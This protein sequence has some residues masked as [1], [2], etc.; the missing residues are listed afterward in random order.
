V[1]RKESKKATTVRKKTAIYIFPLLSLLFVNVC[2]LSTNPSRELENYEHLTP[3]SSLLLEFEQKEYAVQDTYITHLDPA[4]NFGNESYLHVSNH[5]SGLSMIFLYFQITTKVYDKSVFLSLTSTAGFGNAVLSLYTV[6]EE[7]DEYNVTF[8]KCPPIGEYIQNCSQG[9]RLANSY[10]YT[11]SFDVTSAIQNQPSLN[12][13]IILENSTDHEIFFSREGS[14]GEYSPRLIWSPNEQGLLNIISPDPSISYGIE[15]P[16]RIEWEYLGPALGIVN[17]QF[18][19]LKSY[20]DGTNNKYVVVLES[21]ANISMNETTVLTRNGLLFDYYY[22]FNVFFIKF[23]SSSYPAM[24]ICSEPFLTHTQMCILPAW[25][26]FTSLLIFLIPLILFVISIII[27][28]RH[29]KKKQDIKMFSP[30]ENYA[31]NTELDGASQGISEKGNQK[32]QDLPGSTDAK[33][34]GSINESNGKLMVVPEDGVRN[35]Q[36][37]QDS[38]IVNLILTHGINKGFEIIRNVLDD[39]GDVDKS[40]L[41]SETLRRMNNILQNYGYYL[42]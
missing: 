26:W 32:D 40:M 8:D 9:I 17:L 19:A 22:D 23:E 35:S 41:N 36:N 38:A 1:S 15:S 7:W 20:D 12:V 16:L 29:R 30:Q 25:N 34:K 24:D 5:S 18:C 4:R 11:Y 21:I 2:L 13:A 28:K 27:I 6:T 42:A 37:F 10:R 33:K 31:I 14:A 39:Q 3:K